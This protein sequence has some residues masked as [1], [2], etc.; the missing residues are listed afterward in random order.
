MDENGECKWTVNEDQVSE[1]KDCMTGCGISVESDE[2]KKPCICSMIYNPVCCDNKNYANP[3]MAKCD[4]YAAD[5]CR[6]GRCEECNCADVYK[7]ICCNDITYPN[8]CTAECEGIAA[9]AKAQDE[10]EIGQCP[11]SEL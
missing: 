4:G 11:K 1:Y 9:P 6:L 3:C 10:C 8:E 7:P 2:N 5:K